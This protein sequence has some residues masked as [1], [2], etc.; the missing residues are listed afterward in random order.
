MTRTKPLALAL[1]LAL[2]AA[3]TALPE[4]EAR[5]GATLRDPVLEALLRG[6]TP[7]EVSEAPDAPDVV[8]EEGSGPARSPFLGEGVPDSDEPDPE[9]DRLLERM[10]EARGGIR[11]VEAKAVRIRTTPLLSDREDR[12]EGTFR[13]EA[14][15]LLHLELR[16]AMHHAPED[17]RTRRSI[18]TERYAYLWRVEENEAERVELPD[19]E[20]ASVAGGN[21][22][23]DGLAAD[24]GNLK[25]DY[26]LTLLGQ[27]AVEGRKTHLLRARPRPHLKDARF[28]ELGFWVDDEHLFPIQFRQVQS[29]GEIADTYR[30]S[31]IRLNPRWRTNPFRPPPASVNLIVHEVPEAR[32]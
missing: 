11:R 1:L 25:K 10:N 29:R 8:V 30:L 16:G 7:P 32:R 26:F 6:E 17:Q 5:P 2:A 18:V 9:L 28:D 19:A 21:P 20:D 31:N 23:E 15:R 13:F 27:E 4:G 3:R 14:P 24:M 12:H 22:L